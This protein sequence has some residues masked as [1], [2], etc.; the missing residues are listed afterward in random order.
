MKR[1]LLKA[2]MFQLCLVRPWANLF[3]GYC[4]LIIFVNELPFMPFLWDDALWNTNLTFILPLALNN[5][6]KFISLNQ[7]PLVFCYSLIVA[8]WFFLA[9]QLFICYFTHAVKFHEVNYLSQLSI[10]IHSHLPMLL[11]NIINKALS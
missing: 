8:S 3:L 7:I 5:W 10:T 4:Y 2:I 1:L 6:L 11:E 9:I